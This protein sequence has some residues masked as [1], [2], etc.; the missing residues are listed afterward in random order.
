MTFAEFL[1]VIVSIHLGVINLVPF[2]ILDGGH[3]LFL[4][5][6]KIRGKPVSDKTMIIAQYVGLSLLVLLLVYVTSND[7]TRLIP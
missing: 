2:P 6:E 5:I 1:L 7:I 3:I 4:L